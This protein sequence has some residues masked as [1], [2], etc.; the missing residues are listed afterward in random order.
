MLIDVKIENNE[1]L[2]V[3]CGPTTTGKTGIARRILK[4]Y[5]G[6]N[7]EFITC[8][9]IDYKNVQKS[10]HEYTFLKHS[11]KKIKCAIEEKKFIVIK[12][13]IVTEAELYTLLAALRMLGYKGSITLI[14]MD[15]DEET[16]IKYLINRKRAGKPTLKELKRQR[17]VFYEQIL[18]NQDF[19]YLTDMY[20][21]GDPNSVKIRFV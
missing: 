5:E 9:D 14:M 1:G 13:D 16:H 19:D 4:K 8:D 20:I 17:K 6:T 10:K 15:I 12:S 18:P 11:L 7:G 21:I 3:L 2:V